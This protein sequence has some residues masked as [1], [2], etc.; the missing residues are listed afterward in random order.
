MQDLGGCAAHEAGRCVVAK[1]SFKGPFRLPCRAVGRL[2]TVA[3][4]ARSAAAST[5]P[6]EASAGLARPRRWVG[7]SSRLT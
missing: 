4:L 1:K 6:G 7:S 3:S 5:S 2:A